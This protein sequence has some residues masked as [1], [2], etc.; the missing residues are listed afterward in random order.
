MAREEV[1]SLFAELERIASS[2]PTSGLKLRRYPSEQWLLYVDLE[3]VT[4]CVH[5]QSLYDSTLKESDLSVVI[6]SKWPEQVIRSHEHYSFDLTVTRQRV[7]RSA[8]HQTK[9]LTT[10]QLAS[11]VLSSLLAELKNQEARSTRR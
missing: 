9:T 8:R 1:K 7:W 2:S 6:E 3:G 5:W 4:A 10:K 11:D